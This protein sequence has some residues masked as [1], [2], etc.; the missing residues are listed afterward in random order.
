MNRYLLIAMS[1]LSL[2]ASVHG[3]EVV[4]TNA[5]HPVASGDRMGDAQK[6]VE[7]RL[8]SGNGMLVAAA[9]TPGSRFIDIAG[10][11]A[12]VTGKLFALAFDRDNNDS[13]G[14]SPKFAHSVKG[15][16]RQVAIE[17]CADEKGKPVEPHCVNGFWANNLGGAH[18]RVTVDD[19]A[20]STSDEV[21]FEG[22]KVTAKD[23]EIRVEIPYTR[24]GV[25]AGDTIRVYL[26]GWQASGSYGPLAKPVTLALE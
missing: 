6:V 17:V 4:V 26:L 22:G 20:D 3:A 10:E 11:T 8:E 12:V 7:L 15:I 13:T 19:L 18:T 2:C 21:T 9:K 1:A 5:D 14:G 25:S 16:E 24:L 23:D